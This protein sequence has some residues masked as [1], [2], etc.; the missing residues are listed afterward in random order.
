M[1]SLSQSNLAVAFLK[2][3]AYANEMSLRVIPFNN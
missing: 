2:A 1:T 3:F